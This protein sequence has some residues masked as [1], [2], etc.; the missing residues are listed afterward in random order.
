MCADLTLCFFALFLLFLVQTCKSKLQG[1]ATESAQLAALQQE[2][3]NL[4]RASDVDL[5]IK[6]RPL[7]AALQQLTDQQSSALKANQVG[8]QQLNESIASLHKTALAVPFMQTNL[9][10][11]MILSERAWYLQQMIGDSM[12]LVSGARMCST[13]QHAQLHATSIGQSEAHSV[14]APVYL[15][16]RQSD[17]KLLYRGSRDGWT[18]KDWAAKCAG[19]SHT[20]TLIKVSRRLL[21][22][23][24]RSECAVDVCRLLTEPC[25][26]FSFA[27]SGGRQRQC[28]WLLPRSDL[29]CRA[30]G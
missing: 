23:D 11:S 16:D 13:W 1:V 24:L 20:L 4:L 25:C 14:L 21:R 22:S 28:I 12:K 17:A 8:L 27:C 29:G 5:V 18:H 2:G 26:S 10:G 6:A 19:Q 7:K 3:T 15:L 30:G 9:L